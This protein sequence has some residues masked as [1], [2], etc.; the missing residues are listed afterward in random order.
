MRKIYFLL[1]I[2]VLSSCT[3]AKKDL[4]AQEIIDRSIAASNVSLISNTSISFDFRERT[5]NAD[6]HNGVFSLERITKKGD[7]ITKDVLSNTG[8][9]RYVDDQLVQVSDSM[10]IKYSE[11]INSVHYFAVLPYGLNDLAVQ[12]KLLG[13]INIKGKQYYKIQVTFK[14]EGGGIDYQD[15]FVYWIGKEDFKIDYLAYEFHVNGGGVR[16]REVI[17]ES[18]VAG[19]RFVNHANYKSKNNTKVVSE[20]DKEFINGDLVRLSEINLENINVYLKK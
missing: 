14:Q 6:R 13:E 4:S 3:T 10:A 18:N 12:K 8:F 5:Y 1:G 11:S 17:K 16:F 20:L 9:K 2:I 15:V 7:S 19:I